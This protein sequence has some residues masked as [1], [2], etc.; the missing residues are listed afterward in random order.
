MRDINNNIYLITYVH[1]YLVFCNTIFLLIE[2]ATLDKY[3]TLY[4]WHKV[5]VTHYFALCS[6]RSNAKTKILLE[7]EDNFQSTKLFWVINVR[8]RHQQRT[9]QQLHVWQEKAGITSPNE[10]YEIFE[11]AF[12]VHQ[13]GQ[14][15]R[16]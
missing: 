4:N 9:H 12:V 15:N 13:L 6:T 10:F 11:D 7:L 3:L 5:Y 8:K 1:F 14:L 16:L 2:N